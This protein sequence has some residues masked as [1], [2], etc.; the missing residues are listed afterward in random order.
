MSESNKLCLVRCEKDHILF[1][2][3]QVRTEA[4]LQAVVDALPFGQRVWCSSTMDWPNDV[5]DD[6]HLIYLCDLVRG[7]NVSGQN[8]KFRVIEQ[9]K[10]DE[11]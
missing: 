1:G 3:T 11:H 6:N 8:P 2:D 4:E 5:T 9:E 7:N 10:G